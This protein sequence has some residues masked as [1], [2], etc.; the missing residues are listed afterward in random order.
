MKS[1]FRQII[2]DF[3]QTDLPAPKGRELRLASLP[4]HVRKVFVLVGMRRSGK[5][6]SLYQRM[7]QLLEEGIAKQ[8]IVY[9]MLIAF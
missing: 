8:Q 5:T 3:H 6:W 1:V 2:I 9:L 4:S 7:Q